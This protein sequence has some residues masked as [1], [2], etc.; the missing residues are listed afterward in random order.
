MAD[1]SEDDK[2]LIAL[3][4]NCLWEVSETAKT[5]DEERN[6]ALVNLTVVRAREMWSLKSSLKW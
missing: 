4:G 2:D 6:C 5:K 3:V 1:W